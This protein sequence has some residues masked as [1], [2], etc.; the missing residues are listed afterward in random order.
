MPRT[1]TRRGF[2]PDLAAYLEETGETQ[3]ALAARVGASQAQVSRIAAGEVIPRAAL[4]A[5]LAAACRVSLESFTRAY[6]AR[7]E[8]HDAVEPKPRRRADHIQRA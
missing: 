2:Y 6:L 3:T 7:Q 8:S 5:R 4:A 1:R